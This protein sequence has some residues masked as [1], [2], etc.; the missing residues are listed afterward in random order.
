MAACTVALGIQAMATK[1][2]SFTLSPTPITVRKETQT[3]TRRPPI[4]TRT[5]FQMLSTF[6][7]T[8]NIYRIG[9]KYI[10]YIEYIEDIEY[11]EYK[12]PGFPDH[13]D[14]NLTILW[15]HTNHTKISLL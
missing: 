13:A 7:N 3:R 8:Q 15:H 10:E 12:E 2:C 9:G 11:I 4:S 6:T 1:S 5:A 14:H